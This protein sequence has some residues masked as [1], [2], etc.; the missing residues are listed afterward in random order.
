MREYSKEPENRSRT[1][2]SNPQASRQASVD[3]ILQQ[4]MHTTQRYAV[5]GEDAQEPVP[6]EE[7]AD[8]TGLPDKL[9]T[10]IENLSG[11]SM[12]EVRVYSDSDKPAQ[13]QASA[14]MQGTDMHV[15]P[16]QEK[17]LPHETWQVVQQKQGRVQPTLLLR[18]SGVNEDKKPEKE[19][20]EMGM[21]AGDK[22]VRG[23]V[24]LEKKQAATSVIQ[25]ADDDETTESPKTPPTTAVTTPPKTTATTATTTPE[26]DEKP[27][28]EV[29]EMVAEATKKKPCEIKEICVGVSFRTDSYGGAH[30]T[31][32]LQAIE[33]MN[34]LGLPFHVTAVTLPRGAEGGE[35]PDRVA[36]PGEL[37]GIDMFYIPGAPT[38]N[39]T[40]TGSGQDADFNRL[41]EPRPV[42]PPE[43]LPAEIPEKP[44]MPV[45]PKDGTSDDIR[46]YKAK[47]KEIKQSPQYKAYTQYLAREKQFEKAQA[48]YVAYQQ[49]LQNY[50]RK[51][52]EHTGRASYELKLIEMAKSR[53]IPI[54]AVCAGSWRLLQSYGGTVR[55]L[56][57][58]QRALHKV[59]GSM[60]IWDLHHGITVT[61]G[62][63]LDSMMNPYVKSTEDVPEIVGVNTTHWAVAN[64]FKDERR[65]KIAKETVMGVEP[66]GLLDISARTSGSDATTHTVEGFES[67]LGIPVLGLQWHPEAYLPGMKGERAGSE[68]IRQGSRNI[69]KNMAKVAA[70]AKLRRVAVPRRFF[71]IMKKRIQAHHKPE[72]ATEIPAL[73]LLPDSGEQPDDEEL[74]LE[75]D[76]QA[77]AKRYPPGMQLRFECRRNKYDCIAVVLSVEE[78]HAR[79]ENLGH[80]MIEDEKATAI[81]PA[82]AWKTLKGDSTEKIIAPHVVVKAVKMID[83]TTGVE[84]DY[85]SLSTPDARNGLFTLCERDI[86][87]IE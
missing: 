77:V 7:K 45:Y 80:L 64:E 30:V 40:Q 28:K 25:K 36:M 85:G 53:G 49:A 32:D 68:E 1:L 59:T 42:D 79:T 5:K 29:I 63:L 81:V 39:D 11:Y 33:G 23:S 27:R 16:R 70:I 65:S 75:M 17:H 21:L 15:A 18:G 69:F 58:P 8:P 37:D 71:A 51:Y 35:S 60:P 62:S 66:N 55:T 84:I 67:A 72:E 19:V 83:H 87:I 74:P 13:L 3:V 43:E 4:Y 38:A 86:I 10:S 34:Q 44:L 22:E 31:H 56:P 82:T 12:D 50:E 52:K 78:M 9:K 24:E 2:P 47:E 46:D 41:I 14:Y 20:D 61:E 26:E 54:I 48:E 57:E 73:P 6:Q 76:A